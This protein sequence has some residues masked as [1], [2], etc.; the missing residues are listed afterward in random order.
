[1]LCLVGV[2]VMLYEFDWVNVIN[3][4]HVEKFLMAPALVLCT[5]RKQEDDKDLV[6]CLEFWNLISNN[7]SW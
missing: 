6:S 5:T 4:L 3:W 1:M 7:Y 2:D